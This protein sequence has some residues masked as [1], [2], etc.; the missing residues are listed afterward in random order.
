[1]FPKDPIRNA[2]QILSNLN[3]VFPAAA[4]PSSVRA[5]AADRLGHAAADHGRTWRWCWSLGARLRL[6][7]LAQMAAILPKRENDLVRLQMDAIGVIDFDQGTAELDATLV[8][9]AAVEE[10][11]A[12]GRHG[13]AAEVGRGRRTSRWRWA[14]CIR[15]STRRRISR[16]WNGSR[17]IWLPGTTRGSALRSVLRADVEHGA[18]WGA[19]GTVRVRRRGSAFTGRSGLTC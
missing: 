5:D 4:G 19:G 9:L 18:V 15:R 1:M 17:S 3:K 11:R 14:G 7:I 8:R 6:L 13:D 16:N 2:P 10:V 12:D